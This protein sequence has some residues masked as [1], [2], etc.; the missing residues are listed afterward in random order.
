[1]NFTVAIPAYIAGGTIER[2]LSSIAAQS[3][4]QTQNRIIVVNGGSMDG[5]VARVSGHSVCQLCPCK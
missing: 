2:A 5:T 3:Q 4:S 1:M